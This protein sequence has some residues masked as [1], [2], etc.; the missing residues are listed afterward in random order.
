MPLLT[1]AAFP[2]GRLFVSDS[3]NSRI[4]VTT[5][6]GKFLGQ[7]GGAQ[8]ADPIERT[9]GRRYALFS[10]GENDGHRDG[11][12]E[13]ALF[14]NPQVRRPPLTISGPHLADPM[15]RLHRRV[16]RSTP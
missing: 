5:L 15:G 7:I 16:W 9:D 11:S 8:R 14:R 12:F 1:T 6:E 2:S 10:E 3:G 13:E 4:L